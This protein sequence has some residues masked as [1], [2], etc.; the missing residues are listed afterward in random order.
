MK[1]AAE[2]WLKLECL[3]IMKNLSNRLYLKSKFFTF[4][5]TEGKRCSCTY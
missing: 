1:L 2:V 5:M 4:K 3:Y